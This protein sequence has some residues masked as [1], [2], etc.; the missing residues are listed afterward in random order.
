MGT[1]PSPARYRFVG[2]F[3][4]P[5]NILGQLERALEINMNGRGNV[6]VAGRPHHLIQKFTPVTGASR[7]GA[8]SWPS[9]RE[10]GQ[11]RGRV[12]REGDRR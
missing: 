4:T 6:F 2:A 12:R 9:S 3:G 1:D 11:R 5:G 8:E 10:S 7:L